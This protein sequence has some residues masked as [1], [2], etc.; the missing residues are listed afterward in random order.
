MIATPGPPGPP[1]GEV[2]WAS[3][4]DIRELGHLSDEALTGIAMECLWA[5]GECAARAGR[6]Y[7]LHY[8]RYFHGVP[9]RLHRAATRLR[10]LWETDRVAAWEILQRYQTNPLTPPEEPGPPEVP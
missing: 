10:V 3:L 7:T 5:S 9:E 2:P 4:E 6:L 8:H 1:T